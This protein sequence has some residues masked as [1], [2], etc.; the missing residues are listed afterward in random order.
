MNILI[1]G[2]GLCVLLFL[3]C[4]IGIR[5]GAVGLIHLYE[6]DVQQRAIEQGLTTAEKIKQNAVCFKMTGAILYMAYP[7]ICV[8]AVNGTRGFWSGF[9]QLTALFLMMGVF[10]RIGIDVIW[11]GHTKAW[12][13][14]GTED[15]KPY[16]PFKIHLKKWITML[17]LYPAVAAILSGIMALIL[18]S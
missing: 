4:L 3:F 13:I 5:N 11:V 7:L 8:Y 14:P 1:E 12:E 2:F 10:D 17:F 16:I 9:W 15:L 6:K 18:K